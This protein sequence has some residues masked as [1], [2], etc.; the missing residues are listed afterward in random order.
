[1][2]PFVQKL[3]VPVRLASLGCEPFEGL[4]WLSPNAELH[5]GPETLLE[6]LNTP[7]RVLPC[8]QAGDGGV[9]LLVRAQLEWVLAGPEVAPELVRP[10][11]FTPTREERVS[12]RT[13]AGGAYEGVLAIDMPHE[14][15][16]PSDFLNGEADFFVLR[17][18][19]G[20][21][22]F[23]KSCVLEIRVHAAAGLR[24]TA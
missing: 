15:N 4:L 3:R 21:M 20:A 18:D 12:V 10:P 17:T 2:P 6:R 7:T 5:E 23:N 9:R 14:F 8:L 19:A 24:H 16:R 1:M 11:H 13:L 22:L